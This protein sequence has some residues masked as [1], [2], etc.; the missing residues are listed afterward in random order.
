MADT[1]RRQGSF[2]ESIGWYRETLDVDPKF[3][4]AHAGLGRVL[5][6]LA[7]YEEASRSLARAL[8]LRPDAAQ[9]DTRHFLAEAL[10]QLGRNKEAIE[11]YRDVLDID[12]GFAY[13]QAGIGYA[14][15]DMERYEESL[16]WLARSVSVEPEAPAAANRYS[17]MGQTSEALGQP[18]MAAEHYARALEADPENAGALD[19]LALLRFRQQRYEEALGFYRSLVEIDET[20]ARAHLNMGLTQHYLDRPE[21]AR[22]SIQRAVMLDPTLAQTGLEE[23]PDTPQKGYR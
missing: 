22:R 18:E 20:N 11:R 1:R 6:H 17:M 4:L 10:R 7:R 23:S 13:A 3:A 5:F 12:P 21:E 19:A 15:F 9:I 2:E 16:E 14:L 8:S